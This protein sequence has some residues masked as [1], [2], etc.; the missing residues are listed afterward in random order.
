MINFIEK[1]AIA[2]CGVL[3]VETAHAL[4]YIKGAAA[5]LASQEK[6]S[7]DHETD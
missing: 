2:A 3:I 4:G 7:K 5:V 1:M 6:E